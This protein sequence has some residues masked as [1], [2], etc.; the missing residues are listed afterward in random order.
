MGDDSGR[1]PFDKLRAGGAAALIG[2]GSGLGPSLNALR[3]YA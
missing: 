3:L 1:G 2:L